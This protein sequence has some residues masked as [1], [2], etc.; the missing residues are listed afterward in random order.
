MS[1]PRILISRQR[2]GEP[3]PRMSISKEGINVLDGGFTAEDA[4]FDSRFAKTELLLSKG[5]ISAL[6][7]NQNGD[8]VLS[9][10]DG[11]QVARFRQATVSYGVTYP[12]IPLVHVFAR[13]A[14][15]GTDDTAEYWVGGALD[16]RFGANAVGG[17]L[18]VWY[19][20]EYPMGFV[21]CTSSGFTLFHSKHDIPFRYAVYAVEIKT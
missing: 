21:R 3:D 12:F 1:L 2:S 5:S 14:A 13:K 17:G 10:W 16:R 6:T 18:T 15:G 20:I 4:L 7:T 11:I 8:Y 9:T 19:G